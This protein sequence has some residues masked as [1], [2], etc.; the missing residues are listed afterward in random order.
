MTFQS[1]RRAARLLPAVLA[2]AAAFALAGCAAGGTG[3]AGSASG[4][5]VFSAVISQT[6]TTPPDPD[7]NYDGPGLNII[8]NTYEGLVSYE[9]GVASPEITGQLATDWTVSEDGLRY[10]F[11]LRDGVVF[12]D[13]TPFTADAVKAAVERRAAVGSGPAYM[14]ADVAE[15]DITDDTHVTLV[16]SAPNNAFLDYLAS[17]FGLKMISP[18]VLDEYADDQAQEYL[19]THDA[20]TGPYVLSAA[21]TG[22]A[23]ELTAFDD[24]WGEAPAYK[25]VELSVDANASS[26][27]LQLE[28]GEIDAALGN[29]SKASMASYEKNDQLAV[30]TFPNMTTQTLFV[31]P[32]SPTLGAD[33]ETR[34]TFFSA[35]DID[36]I[37]DQ[38]MGDI[39][40]PTDRLFPSGMTESGD[41]QGIEYDADALA[42][43]PEE[44]IDSLRI[45]YA[46]SSADGKA[47]AEQIGATLSAWGVPTEVIPF[48]SGS[49]YTMTDDLASAPDLFVMGV[50]P[51]T[52]HPDAWARI[53]YTPAGGLDLF[54]AEVPGLDSALDEALLAD[55]VSVYGSIAQDIIGTGYWYSIGALQTTTVT[56]AGVTGLDAA[57]N[58]LEYN[59]LHFA[60]LGAE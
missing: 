29:I 49:A 25:T 60:A 11:T 2:G 47:V 17:P 39:E 53:L 27:Q 46:A 52:N 57:R 16:L 12:H 35:L 42:Q 51:D 59:V 41:E 21:E 45:G 7:G 28:R 23:Y 9:N 34:R 32:S 48:A 3:S 6:Y 38:A 24:Y 30:S 33:A 22:T 31:N 18:A 5:D 56:A 58:A 36:T 15:V 19:T 40:Q 55:D 43:L 44:G 37:L 26:V 10:D 20:G 1:S 8:Q 13:G 54:G 14:T 4:D 50:F